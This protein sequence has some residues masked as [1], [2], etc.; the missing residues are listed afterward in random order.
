SPGRGAVLTFAGHFTLPRASA[1]TSAAVAATRERSGCAAAFDRSG[2]AAAPDGDEAPS[3]P[4]GASGEPQAASAALMTS[5]KHSL[6][7]AM[8]SPL[9]MLPAGVTVRRRA[10]PVCPAESFR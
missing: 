5:A 6:R 9:R 1:A 10:T 3:A 8:E 4:A 7:V 2:C